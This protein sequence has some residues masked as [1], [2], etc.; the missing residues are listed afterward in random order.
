MRSHTLAKEGE[1]GHYHRMNNDYNHCKS[2][3]YQVKPA[4]LT[5]GTFS[6][7]KVSYGG[8]FMSI[9]KEWLNVAAAYDTAREVG[10]ETNDFVSVNKYC[11]RLF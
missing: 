1:S 4:M 6:P 7:V 2:K 8:A 5:H 11:V 3:A 9:G 10:E